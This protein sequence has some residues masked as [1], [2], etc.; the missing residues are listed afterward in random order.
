MAKNSEKKRPPRIVNK[1]ALRN[2]E[3]LEKI[4]CGLK[5]I[6]TEVKSLREGAARL[7]EAYGRIEDGELYLVGASISP[8][9][10]AAEG[11]QHDPTRKRKLLLHRRQIRQLQTHVKQKGK[12]LVPVAIYFKD[13]RAKVELG[14]AVGK[15]E[16]DKRRDIRE[17]DVQRDIDRAMSRRRRR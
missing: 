11:M 10:Q 17:R 6:G 13:G 9:K 1:K 3:I 16:Y 12:T 8:Y 15:R 2:Y 5:L 14:V 7:D 4:E